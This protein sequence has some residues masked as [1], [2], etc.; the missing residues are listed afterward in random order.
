MDKELKQL[1]TLLE[2]SRTESAGVV[3]FIHGRVGNNEVALQKCGIG[4]VNSTIGAVEMIHRYHPDVII[5]TGCAGGASTDME[6][7]DVVIGTEMVYHDAYCGTAQAFGQVMGM[8][9]RYKAN[10]QLLAM[11]HQV[12]HD[13]Q[14]HEGLIVGG[15]W[16]V[17]SR[18]KMSSILERFPEAVAV[19]MESTSIAQT[20]HIYQVPFISFRVVSD[21]P[22]KDHEASQYFDFWDRMADGSFHVTKKFLEKL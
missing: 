20:C 1:R 16:F 13:A 10:P 22:L 17:D 2:D 14:V 5:S 15:D 18:E 11:A 19:D 21:V 6:I 9:A 7:G 12:E 4:K 8:P 3:E